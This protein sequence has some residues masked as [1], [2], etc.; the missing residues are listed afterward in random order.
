MGNWLSDWSSDGSLGVPSRPVH[1]QEESIQANLQ[2][3]EKCLKQT[4]VT[5][6]PAHKLEEYIQANL[7]PYEESL[8]QI[9]QEVDVIRCLLSMGNLVM[10]VAKGGSYGRETVLRGCSDGTLVLFTDHFR[11]FQDQKEYQDNLLDLFEQQ[12]KSHEKYKKSV[13]RG[14]ALVVQVSKP[15]QSILLQLLPAYNPLIIGLPLQTVYLNLKKSMD[16]VGASPGE[17]SDCFTT[18]QWQFFKKY[19]RRLKDLI[20]LVK[21]WYEQCQE[22]WIIPLPQPS[23]YALELL[24]VYA[25]EQGC[26]AEDFDMVQGVRTVLR[27][28]SQPTELCVYWIV[29][30]NFEDET[31]QNNLLCQLKSP[32]PVILDPTDPTNNVGKGVRFWQ[33]LKEEAQA[34]LDSLSLN[35]SPATYWDVLPMPLF[36]TPS[37]LL[38]K[39]I[40]DFLQP[41]K[42]FIDQIKTAVDII[43]SF[44]KEKCFRNSGTKVLKTVKGGSTAKGTA[45]KQGSDADIV[46]FLSSLESY[47]SLKIKRSW[48]VQKIQ[49]QLEAYMQP[50]ELEVKFA[51]SKWKDPRVLSFTLKSKS[52]NESV[53]FDVLPACDT[54]GQLRSDSTSRTSRTK[55]YKDLIKL[56]TSQDNP[57]GGEFSICFTEL[58]RNFIETRPTKLKGLIRLVKRWYKQ[59]EMKMKPKVSLP[60]K[61]ALEL[62]TVYAWEQGSGIDDFDSAEGFRTVLDLVIKYRQLCIFWTVNYNFEEEYMR[63]F[64]PLGRGRVHSQRETERR[65]PNLGSGRSL[66]TRKDAEAGGRQRALALLSLRRCVCAR[67]SRERSEMAGY[68]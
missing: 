53:E 21:H 13:K 48:F 23:M 34:W 15:G 56:Y 63:F 61:Y 32:R 43:C 2:P 41:D 7:Q 64:S 9:D 55:A 33:L 62:L 67:P 16:G 8:R 66:P 46:V 60:P 20:L 6:V 36:N 3:N 25:W 30:Y 14:D 54:L 4:G 28:V 51:K 5:L 10:G 27:L 1:K 18:L 40:Y 17:F 31:V 29:N 50:L 26:Q 39:F 42:V 49:E 47:D 38:D 37:H 65:K 35:E 44:L 57:K 58:Q 19:P 11:K 24:T 68:P 45:L 12:L 52:L 59:Y 22:K